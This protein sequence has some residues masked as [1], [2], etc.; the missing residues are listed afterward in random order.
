MKRQRRTGLLPILPLAALLTQ[1]GAADEAPFALQK[2]GV[3]HRVV[4]ADISD[5]DGIWRVRCVACVM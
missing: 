1:A 4:Q 3:T 5:L 2:I